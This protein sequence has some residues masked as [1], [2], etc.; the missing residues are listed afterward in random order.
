MTERIPYL[1]LMVAVLVNLLPRPLSAGED[2]AQISLVKSIIVKPYQDGSVNIEERTI[3][4]GD[5]LWGIYRKNY[6]L[7][8]VRISFFLK[9]LKELNPKVTILDRIY[10]GQKISIPFKMVNADEEVSQPAEPSPASLQ[11]PTPEAERQNKRE[12]LFTALRQL[13]VALGMNS[14]FSG[15]HPLMAGLN[16]TLSIDAALTP[17]VE[18]S[19]SDKL[20]LDFEATLPPERRATIASIHSNILQYRILDLI[21]KDDFGASIDK[22]LRALRFYAVERKPNPLTIMADTEYRIE[23]DWFV[24]KS[25]SLTEICVVNLVDCTS[26]PANCGSS[27]QTSPL[28]V[29]GYSIKFVTAPVQ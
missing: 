24:F 17:V 26:D 8:P 16:G 6:Q 13:T 4:K 18:V 25:E 2:E 23:G 10:P 5:S 15:A 1:F 19:R 9:I 11:P 3:K 29:N 20:I 14:I 27:R 22:F 28:E 21:E 7:S 12:K